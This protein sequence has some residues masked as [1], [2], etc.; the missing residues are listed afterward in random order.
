M[1]QTPAHSSRPATV[2]KVDLPRYMGEWRVIAHVPYFLEKGKVDTSDIYRLRPD[3]Q[4]DNIFQFRKKNMDAPL[5][6]WKARAWVVNQQSQAE[7]KL[8]FI[9]PFTTTYLVVDLDPDYQ[10]S[11]VTIPSRK[12]IWILARERSLPPATYQA[13]VARLKTKGFDTTKLALVPQGPG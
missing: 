9:W 13:I 1:N 4:I 5:Q 7:W 6:Q 10:W 8:Q 3:G 2:S 12:L 11:V